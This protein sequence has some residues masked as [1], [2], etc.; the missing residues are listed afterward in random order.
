VRDQPKL[1]GAV[2]YGLGIGPTIGVYG[3]TLA[4]GVTLD[5][6]LQEEVEW[7]GNFNDF[8]T[9]Q[10]PY[11]DPSYGG[12]EN[13][14]FLDFGY[15]SKHVWSLLFQGTAAL[16]GYGFNAL[17]ASTP[18][19]KVELDSR[20]LLP[21]LS[22]TYTYEME[23][24]YLTFHT[25]IKGKAVTYPNM[26]LMFYNT[27]SSTFEVIDAFD[28]TLSDGQINALEAG[29]DS[30]QIT[31]TGLLS[32][33]KLYLYA[34]PAYEMNGNYYPIRHGYRTSFDAHASQ[35]LTAV[36]EI[37]KDIRA[38]SAGE[39]EGCNWEENLS[40]SD[41]T[42]IEFSNYGFGG[43]KSLSITIPQEWELASE[44]KVGNHCTAIVD[45]FYWSIE[46][47][48]MEHPFD[49][50][51][52]L[53]PC[54]SY[55]L[56]GDEVNTL[57]M[58]SKIWDGSNW[59]LSYIPE[60][61]KTLDIS[62]S[63]IPNFTL[64]ANVRNLEVLKVDNCAKLNNLTMCMHNTTTQISAN[65]CAKLNIVSIDSLRS[66]YSWTYDCKVLSFPHASIGS[67]T[68]SGLSRLQSLYCDGAGLTALSVSNLPNVIDLRC[69]NNPGLTGVML[70][71]FDEMFNRGYAPKYDQRYTYNADGTVK[72]DL[73]Y[74]FYYADEPERG[75]H[76]K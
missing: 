1:S 59:K 69:N 22:T 60:Q 58:R 70:P 12:Y 6:L 5:C 43:R 37:L 8:D 48:D 20:Q 29:A 74:G 73:G 41:M 65:N 17:R 3:Q 53:D 2:K 24:N 31:A 54:C 66:D 57:V 33:G 63:S 50:V 36:K 39:W 46:C 7:A 75:Y 14:T 47:Y 4:V 21:N 11:I 68:V 16:K 52:I 45:S 13:S 38:C 64:P 25:W 67:L 26:R 49:K 10:T 27:N 19:V 18:D 30:V 56:T 76:R 15:D 34:S 32:E 44:L 9:D 28:F 61:L 72:S 51:E 71:L 55:V 42:N 23:G 40:L 62:E 35:Y